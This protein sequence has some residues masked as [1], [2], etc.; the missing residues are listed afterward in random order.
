M[1]TAEVAPAAVVLR[2]IAQT[3]MASVG[4][5]RGKRRRTIIP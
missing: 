4:A 3:L 5:R 1:Q 2:A